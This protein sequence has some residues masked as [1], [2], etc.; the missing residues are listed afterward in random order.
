LKI[1]AEAFSALVGIAHR[2]KDLLRAETGQKQGQSAVSK[3]RVQVFCTNYLPCQE[4]TPGSLSGEFLSQSLI[5]AQAA[6]D[7]EVIRSALR[8]A[9]EL[10]GHD[11]DLS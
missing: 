4:W 2:R 11:K 3:P 10:N 6:E 1:N 9:R 8:K 5:R 7:A